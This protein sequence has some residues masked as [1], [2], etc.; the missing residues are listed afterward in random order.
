VCLATK[1]PVVIA[2]AMNQ[3]MWQDTATN[4]N[5]QALRQKGMHL[6][7]PA[8]GSQACGDIGL[9]RMLE[10]AQIIEKLSA[11]FATGMLAGMKVLVTAGPTHEAIDPVR[12]LTNGSSGKMGY[13]LAAAAEEAGATVTLISGPVY[14]PPPP[15]MEVVSVTTAEQMYTAVM[16]KVAEY[17]IF[18][19]VAAVADY[20]CQTPS[21][22]KIHKKE[23]V[24]QLA[25]TRNPDIVESVGQLSPRPFVV[26]FAAET[27]EVVQQAQAKRIRKNMDM[28]IANQV[29]A[30]IGMGSDEN[31]V[32]VIS[33]Q[34]TQHLPLT[35][36]N[37][38]AR[39]LIEIIAAA[40]KENIT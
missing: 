1:A 6:L 13:A 33:D 20:R 38:L 32:V 36:K 39:Q 28:I 19:A 4:A 17:D 21:E 12:Y 16:R 26:G 18:L 30:G 31:A 3:G 5:Q 34:G 22:Q 15:R 11:L 14:L 27:E 37:K 9:G 7:G 24:M 25:L 23:A 35:P 40:V 10:P 8:S 2:P 29:G